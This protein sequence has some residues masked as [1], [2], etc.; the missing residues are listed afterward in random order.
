[1]GTHPIF[2]SD[3]DCLTANMSETQANQ[4]VAAEH[5][6]GNQ[7]GS[8]STNPGPVRP[9]PALT[10]GAGN[11]KQLRH[12]RNRIKEVKAELPKPAIKLEEPVIKLEEPAIKLEEPAIKL[13]EPSMKLE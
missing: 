3:F 4:L 7:Q 9:G 5:E 8:T 11:K 1:M 13:E 12:N 10:G 6:S 2:E